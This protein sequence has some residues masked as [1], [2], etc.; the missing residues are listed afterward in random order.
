MAPHRYWR[1]RFPVAALYQGCTKFELRATAGGADQTG[2]GTPLA[3]SY[4]TGYEP[5][6]AFDAD[7]WTKWTSDFVSGEHWLGYDFGSGNAVSVAQ[8]AWWPGPNYYATFPDWVL[9]ASDD[10]ST[11]SLVE[12]LPAQSDWSGGP[13]GELRVF[14]L[15]TEAAAFDA[16]LG[17]ISLSRYHPGLGWQQFFPNAGSLSLAGQPLANLPRGD[18]L[19]AGHAPEVRQSVP[20]GALALAGGSSPL[21]S[22]VQA[23][24][25]AG[26]L[27]LVGIY[28]ENTVVQVA[29]RG[30]LRL[31][32]H[33]AAYQWSA[34]E[35]GQPVYLL[36]LTGAAD[37]LAEVTLPLASFD[38]RW[39]DGEPSYLSAVVPNAYAYAQAI[40][41]RPN[42]D[43]VLRRGVRLPDGRFQTAE[44][45]RVNL[46][47]I[48]D[49]RGGRSASIT[50]SGHKTESA[51]TGKTVT[52]R[53][54]SYRHTG[55]GP[56]RYRCAPD[57]FLRPGDTAEF[58]ELGES[59]VVGSL[60][61]SV[62]AGRETLEVTEAE[63]PA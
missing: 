46:D 31:A 38:A 1:V 23:R 40:A 13:Y 12:T 36:V 44:I 51:A 9:E 18:L 4:S 5:A 33:A 47:T 39:K 37:G 27:A 29:S 48:A 42:G 32:K 55:T 34:P 26:A 60:S 20:V 10:G 45:G 24:P 21:V 59:M 28:L 62:S 25:G 61:Y 17:Q 15:Q 7:E 14:T 57:T 30:A 43:L 35:G 22:P 50:L 49:D 54:V 6:Y 53:G 63:A 41:D 16:P 11:W 3:D 19:L 56:R 8:I 58:P 2:S 52:L